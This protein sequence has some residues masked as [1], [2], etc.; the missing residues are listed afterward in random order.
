MTYDIS[1]NWFDQLITGMIYCIGLNQDF[2]SPIK[3]G[4]AT[5]VDKRLSQIQS[6]NPYTLYVLTAIPGNEECE[7]VIHKYFEKYKVRQSGEWYWPSHKIRRIVSRM[8]N[9]ERF[10]RSEHKEQVR[11]ALQD[12]GNDTINDIMPDISHLDIVVRSQRFI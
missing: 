5:N 7:K 1:F 10:L 4:F 11:N 2:E 6:G 3:F 12:P 9:I 8:T